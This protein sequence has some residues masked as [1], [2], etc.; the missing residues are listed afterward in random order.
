MAE[1]SSVT[2]EDLRA[3]LVE[4]LQATHVAIEDMSG[5]FCPTIAPPVL[6]PASTRA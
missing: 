4:L 5:I 2:E 3:K 1:A 6:H